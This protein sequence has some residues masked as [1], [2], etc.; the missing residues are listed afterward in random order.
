MIWGKL[1]W[2]SGKLTSETNCYPLEIVC[3]WGHLVPELA[4][5]VELKFSFFRFLDKQVPVWVAETDESW[6]AWVRLPTC[7]GSPISSTHFCSWHQDPSFPLEHCSLCLVHMLT[8]AHVLTLLN[9]H[10]YQY[11]VWPMA[12]LVPTLT[13]FKCIHVNPIYMP[14]TC[15][16][17]SWVHFLR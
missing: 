15:N 16:F 6:H 12:L 10:H 9:V 2:V 5:V 1:A 8:V 14:N 4:D 3:L 17:V 13:W 11:D 7:S